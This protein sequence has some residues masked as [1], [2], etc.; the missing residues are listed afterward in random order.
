RYMHKEFWIV[1]D[2]P[3]TIGRDERNRPHC[4]TGPQLRW[5]DGWELFFWHGVR[6]PAQVVEHP[7]TLT[8]AQVDKEQNAEVRR[9][10]IERMGLGKYVRE[11]G[12]RVVHEDKDSLGF[13][14]RLLW[15]DVP[16][17]DPIVVCEVTNSSTEPDGSRKLYH[18]CVHHEL[19][20]LLDGDRMGDAQEL[21]CHNAVAST[22]GL[23]GEDYQPQVET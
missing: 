23:R 10:M 8:V 17:H 19:R 16:D 5:R 3:K 2:F 12:A 7:E 6:V 22:F 11:S 4:A 9:V 1:S 20:P 13:P 21:T 15:R 14:R 18:L